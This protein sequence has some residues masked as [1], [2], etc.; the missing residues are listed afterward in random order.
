[1]VSFLRNSLEILGPISQQIQATLEKKTFAD[2]PITIPN[3]ESPDAKLDAV[4]TMW[5]PPVMFVGL[6]SPQ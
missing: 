3:R 6:D 5:G 2:H 4:G 1:M